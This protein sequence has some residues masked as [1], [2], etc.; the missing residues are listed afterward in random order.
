MLYGT[1]RVEAQRAQA[2]STIMN[3]LTET[4]EFDK[5]KIVKSTHKES[6]RRFSA[7]T[8]CPQ[9][10]HADIVVATIP[11]DNAQTMGRN[12]QNA[13]KVATSERCVGTGEAESRMRCNKKQP[14]IV[15]MKTALTW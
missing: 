7:L 12:S 4:K 9:N 5:L 6:L 1:K 15:Q 11:Q 13:A 10:S 2:Q 3:S 8:K 14:K